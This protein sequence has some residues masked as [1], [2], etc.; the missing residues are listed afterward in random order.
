MNTLQ[1]R[2]ADLERRTPPRQIPRPDPWTLAAEA[3]WAEMPDRAAQHAFLDL[4]R[5]ANAA[6]T[7]AL[8]T[9][10]PAPDSV[11]A[12]CTQILGQRIMARLD[13]LTGGDPVVLARLCH[14]SVA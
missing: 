10:Q 1:K 13:E 9:D 4:V 5:G 12:A 6:I 14:C 2:L 7:C 8:D 3:I 11:T